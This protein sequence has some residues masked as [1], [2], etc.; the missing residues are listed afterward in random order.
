M[1]RARQLI[2]PENGHTDNPIRVLSGPAISR[3]MPSGITTAL[4]EALQQQD[5]KAQRR[6]YE[7][8][9]PQAMK[10]CRRY[11]P[12]PEEAMETLNAGFLKVFTQ[13]GKYT[14][15][16]SFEGWVHRIMVNEALDHLRQEKKYNQQNYHPEQWEDYSDEDAEE[17]ELTAIDL[18]TLYRLVNELPTMTRMVFNLYVFDQFSHADIAAELKIAPGTS[19]WHLSNARMMLQGKL[20]AILNKTE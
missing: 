5:R 3:P 12:N 4:I 20:K 17:P 2:Y 9:F 8:L 18:E 13:I 11:F 7:L 15:K 16:G 10:I 1:M 6:V 14:G 19:K